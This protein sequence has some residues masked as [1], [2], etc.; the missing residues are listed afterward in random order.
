MSAQD[1][2][3]W[4]Q[5][6]FELRAADPEMAGKPITRAQEKIIQDHLALV[7]RKVTPAVPDM[8]APFIP[9]PLPGIGPFVPRPTTTDAPWWRDPIICSGTSIKLCVSE[10]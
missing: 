1:F 4:L 10:P 2:A 5:G 9:E 8:P 3:Y 7:F 6:F